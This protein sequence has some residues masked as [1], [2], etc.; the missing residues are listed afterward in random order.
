MPCAEAATQEVEVM[1]VE[2]L[3]EV[4]GELVGLDVWASSLQAHPWEDDDLDASLVLVVGTRPNMWARVWHHVADLPG[5]VGH[6]CVFLYRTRQVFV[7]LI[8]MCQWG[9]MSDSCH[10]DLTSFAM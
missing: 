7:F 5:L 2:P 3:R 9:A 8:V 4:I 10:Q 1:Q 6:T